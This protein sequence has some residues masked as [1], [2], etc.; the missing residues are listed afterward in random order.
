MTMCC[1]IGPRYCPADGTLASDE[2][3]EAA[4]GGYFLRTPHCLPNANPSTNGGNSEYTIGNRMHGMEA[5]VRDAAVAKR[6]TPH[7]GHDGALGNER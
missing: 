3:L 6:R 7:H 4:T 2:Y 5:A 1:Y